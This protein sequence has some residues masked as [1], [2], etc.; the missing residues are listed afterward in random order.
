MCL[1][2]FAFQQHTDIPLIVLTNRDEY[3]ARPTQ[4]AHWWQGNVIFAGRDL[5]SNGTWLGV[6]RQGLFSTVTNIREP[7]RF[8]S[9]KKSRG[10][11]VKNFLLSKQTAKVYLQHLISYDQ[12]Y[13]G[14]NLLLGNSD[15]LWFYSNRERDIRPIK[16]GIYGIS[17]GHFDEP[18]PK[19]VTGKLELT[20][21]LSDEA[22]EKKM[23]AVLNDKKI[24]E[25]YKLPN[26]GV[27]LH[28]ERLLSS[29]FVCTPVYGTRTCTMVTINN[30]NQVTY[31]EQSY[32][33]WGIQSSI[34][35]ERFNII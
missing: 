7:T 21:L 14:F 33:N 9:Q 17:N 34:I 6:N 15:E 25:D 1:I 20:R 35:Q 29:R 13:A 16:S 2:L 28:I 26:T 31:N 30:R 3:Y 23:M 5:V 19:V 24:A 27:S 22:D 12:N 8:V 11:L 18:W 10:D 32:T 4:H